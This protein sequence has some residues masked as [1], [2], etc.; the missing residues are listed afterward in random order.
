MCLNRV[1]DSVTENMMIEE[2]KNDYHTPIFTPS[3]DST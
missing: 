1:L 2:C 3:S